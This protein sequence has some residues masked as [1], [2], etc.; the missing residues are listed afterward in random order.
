MNKHAKQTLCKFAPLSLAACLALAACERAG[1]DE[2]V[3][4]AK[5][6]RDQTN[7]VAMSFKIQPVEYNV[8]KIV[9]TGGEGL[10]GSNKLI[11]TCKA[12]L[13]AEVDFGKAVIK[14]NY[15]EKSISIVLPY[16][17]HTEVSMP[18]DAIFLEYQTKSGMWG[19]LSPDERKK[20]RE[21]GQTEIEKAR[22][23]M[24]ILE[25]AKKYTESFLKSF[26]IN[27]GYDAININITFEP[28]PEPESNP[29]PSKKKNN[30]E[31]VTS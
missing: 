18:P 13:R 2:V 31:K 4:P 3:D 29:S 26:L 7:K 10:W 20:L 19:L 22:E 23:E 27:A 24:G 21:D 15:D 16:P 6:M 12:T 11:Y 9:K 30:E 28:K 25:D 17:R 1:D 14:P 8:T 5:R